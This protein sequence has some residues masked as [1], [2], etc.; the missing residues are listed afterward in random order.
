MVFGT[1][2]QGDAPGWTDPAPIRGLLE[3]ARPDVL[4]HPATEGPPLIADGIAAELGITRAPMSVRPR[5]GE[6]MY[7]HRLV[8]AS[9]FGVIFAVGKAGE[10]SSDLDGGLGWDL[11]RQPVER[12]RDVQRPVVVY[13]EDGVEGPPI[14]AR[15]PK[16]GDL[17]YARDEL[18]RL[19]LA[20]PWARTAIQA[21]G[22]AA[23]DAARQS[24]DGPSFTRELN[25]KIAAAWAAVEALRIREP[26]IAPWLIIAE[27]LLRKWAPRA[28][29]QPQK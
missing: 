9:S 15:F 11:R 12:S 2:P 27:R 26:R 3:V 29:P 17:E 14:R 25:A 6:L 1:A 10:R 8:Q 13:R 21:A 28:L 20:A 4:V 18:R 16:G 23:T 24:G 22:E 19:W 7:R 5:E